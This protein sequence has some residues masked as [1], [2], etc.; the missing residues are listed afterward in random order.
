MKTPKLHRLVFVC[1]LLSG[2]VFEELGTLPPLDLDMTVGE[3]VLVEDSAQDVSMDAAPPDL[4]DAGSCDPGC[5]DGFECVEGQCVCPTGKNVCNGVC[6]V[7]RCGGTCQVCPAV[8][9]GQAS[10]EFDACSIQCDVSGHI[11][12]QGQCIPAGLICEGPKAAPETSCD[13]LLQTGCLEQSYC[14][15]E[16]LPLQACESQG[17]CAL[18]EV[19]LNENGASRCRFYEA[20]CRSTR[21]ASERCMNQF[22]CSGSRICID[23]LCGP[24]NNSSDCLEGTTCVK[25]EMDATGFCRGDVVTTLT[26]GQ[27][28]TETGEP[29]CEAGLVCRAG[30]C[31]KVCTTADGLGCDRTQFCRPLLAGSGLGTCENSC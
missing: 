1:A 25:G 28:C 2:C 6:D 4:V 12:H 29:K 8:E 13:P 17:E 31:R 15:P 9:G 10:C 30:Q 5:E 19:C 23:G 22:E 27:T 16:R 20:V 21:A 14:V 26:L 11:F 7:I 18:G 24:C 3:D